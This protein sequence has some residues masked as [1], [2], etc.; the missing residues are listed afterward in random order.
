V[1]PGHALGRDHPSW[2]RRAMK[3]QSWAASKLSTTIISVIAVVSITPPS[4]WRR[5]LSRGKAYDL[6]HRPWRHCSLGRPRETRRAGR[7]SLCDPVTATVLEGHHL[8]RAVVCEEPWREADAT[9]QIQGTLP[10]EHTGPRGALPHHDRCGRTRA[11]RV[12]PRP[13]GRTER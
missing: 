3:S 8:R 5:L 6:W 11:T 13:P 12:R 4:V 9:G 1:Q 7:A 2:L 10:S